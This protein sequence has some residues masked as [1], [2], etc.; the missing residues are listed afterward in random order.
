MKRTLGYLLFPAALLVVIGIVGSCGYKDEME[1]NIDPVINLYNHPCDGDTLGAA[2]IICWTGFDTDGKVYE[3]EHIDLPKE[4]NGKGIDSLL[5]KTY[6]ENPSLL[7]DVEYLTTIDGNKVRWVH[8]EQTC[9][10][11]FLSLLEQDS[12]TEHFFCVRA[13]D[14]DSS[15]SE[16]V[17]ATYYRTNLPPDSC[18]IT[19]DS[20][21][22]KEFWILRDTTYSW[23]GIKIGWKATDPDNS[24][25][26]EYYWVLLEWDGTEGGDTL[27]SSLLEDTLGGPNSG[28]DSTDG[29]IRNTNTALR[30][31]IPGSGDYLFIVQVR[32]DAFYAGAADSAVI[33]L[34]QPVFDISDSTV[35]QAYADRTFHH[36]VFIVDQNDI[37]GYIHQDTVWAFYEPIFA[38]M[39]SEGLI[40]GYRRENTGYDELEIPRTELADYSIL[41]VLDQ[42]YFFKIQSSFLQELMLYVK[43]G[44]RIVL[45]GR[46]MLSEELESWDELPSYDYFGIDEDYSGSGSQ[47]FAYGIPNT[48]IPGYPELTVD[49]SKT[50]GGAT[51]IRRVNRIGA[52]GPAYGGSPYTQ[53]LYHF[54]ISETASPSDSTNYNLGPVA[55]RYV[56]PSF[57]TACFMFPLYLM[58]NDEGQV[59]EVVRST[60]DFIEQQV[61]PEEEER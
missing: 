19:T 33:T 29:W 34:A 52:R 23:D 56:T 12:T 46:F 51:A 38:E 36:K 7:Q 58:N 49:S 15:F 32:D 37:A 48:Q 25:I 53:I 57:R 6:K 30:G 10:T 45:D 5:Y 43:V 22:D 42:D 17:C 35:R 4:R 14:I 54:G 28:F 21:E 55:V 18:E 2:P 27:I 44:G 20:L 13:V 39:Q 61:I 8:T 47:I 50:P 9:D 26:L 60:I 16:L 3:Y 41:W 31:V 40:Y 24:I 59:E 11:V 1:P